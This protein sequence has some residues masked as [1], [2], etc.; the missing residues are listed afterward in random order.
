MILCRS[1]AAFFHAAP[2][3]PGPTTNTVEALEL[4]RGV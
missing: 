4:S 2:L 1:G 3:G